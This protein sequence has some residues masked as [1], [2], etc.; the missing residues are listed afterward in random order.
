MALQGGDA[1]ALD[2]WCL[3]AVDI[4][5]L[6]QLHIR[7]AFY[8]RDDL[9]RALVAGAGISAAE[10]AALR[11]ADDQFDRAAVAVMPYLAHAG[12]VARQPADS[13]ARTYYD[14]HAGS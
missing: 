9:R 5:N 1:I 3:Y 6:D 13:Y 8:Y 2:S 10:Q 4:P 12:W 14:K 7:E 11:E